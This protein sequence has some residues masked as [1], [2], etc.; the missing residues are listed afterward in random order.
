MISVIVPTC[1]RPAEL[2]RCVQSLERQQYTMDR[3][4]VVVIDDGRAE[5]AARLMRADHKNLSLR[6]VRQD[7]AG[8]AAARARGVA[9]ARGEVLAFL[10]DDCTVPP[11]YLASVEASFARHPET[12]VAQ[13]A[14]EN[15]APDNR[16]GR[17]WAFLVE[18][19][20]RLNVTPVEDG[21]LIATMLGGVFVCRRSVFD[22][23]A[24]DPRF[25]GASEDADLR[26]QLVQAGIPIHYAP[27]IVVYHHWRTTLTASLAQQAWYGRGQAHL[28]RKWGADQ[29]PFRAP[30]LLARATLRTLREREGNLGAAYAIGAL[31]MIRAAGALG[32][33]AEAA[34]I[35]HPDLDLRRRLLF[36]RLLAGYASGEVSRVI[37][38]FSP[39]RRSGRSART[40]P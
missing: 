28:R 11:D 2:L 39:G 4:E 5:G 34:R 3:F 7:H 14:L 22:R 27:D 35:E 17:L 31:L 40:D 38:A 36:A 18:E 8:V 23:V 6:L 26:Y 32:C 29:A 13:V 37:R 19:T 33:A 9:V 12:L 24:W 20:V 1:D 21:R 30:Q 10:D 25:P 15:P 16:H